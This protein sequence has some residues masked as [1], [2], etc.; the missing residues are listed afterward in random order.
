MPN[1]STHSDRP[2]ILDV[3][4]VRRALAAGD[5]EEALC[6][7]RANPNKDWRAETKLM[8]PPKPSFHR[9]NGSRPSVY[10]ILLVRAAIA[11]GN[12]DE[13]EQLMAEHPGR[14]WQTELTALENA[15]RFQRAWH[16]PA[17]N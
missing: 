17:T 14:N 15:P 1:N 4:N 10:A 6:I 12:L 2:F 9:P 5:I 13:A 8:A 16:I 11:D 3:L 7:M